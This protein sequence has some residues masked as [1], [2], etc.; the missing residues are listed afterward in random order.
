MDEK[1]SRSHEQIQGCWETS[2]TT[3]SYSFIKILTPEVEAKWWT[4]STIHNIMV[5]DQESY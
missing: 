4:L 3:L 1:S 2:S 5:T